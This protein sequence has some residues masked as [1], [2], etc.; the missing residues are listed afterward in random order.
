[1]VHTVWG[2]KK[3]YPFITKEI[4][5]LLIDHIKSNAIAKGIYIDT[6]NGYTDHLH[7]LMDLN[8]ENSIGKSMQLLKGESAYWINKEKLTIPKFEW[9]DEYYAVSVDAQNITHT[10]MYIQGQEVHHQKVSF[11]EEYDELIKGFGF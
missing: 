5:P 1:M 6:I 8:P 4:R 2:T 3:R 11:K 7:C 9:S 10:R